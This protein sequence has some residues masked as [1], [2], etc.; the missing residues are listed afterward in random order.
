MCDTANMAGSSNKSKSWS[1]VDQPIPEIDLYFTSE[2]EADAVAEWL[3]GSTGRR[4]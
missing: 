2:G 1:P 3:A 4:P